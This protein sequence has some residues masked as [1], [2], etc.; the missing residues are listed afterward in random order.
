MKKKKLIG[1]KKYASCG[2]WIEMEEKE[3]SADRERRE[4][5]KKINAAAA[6]AA[7]RWPSQARQAAC[8]RTNEKVDFYEE[9]TVVHKVMVDVC[10][11]SRVVRTKFEEWMSAS[12]RNLLKEEAHKR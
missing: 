8:R 10:G 2:S 11:K 6:A 12:P 3:E 5:R 9:Q 4:R 7:A 1:R